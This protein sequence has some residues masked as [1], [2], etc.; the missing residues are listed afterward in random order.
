[1]KLQISFDIVDLD[2]AIEI[3]QKVAP[4]ADIL[5]VGALL[6]YKHGTKAVEEFRSAFPTK[7]L[8]VDAKIID[9]AKEAVT[10]LA[11]S[12]ADWITVMAGTSKQVI[13]SACTTAHELN[14]KVMIDLLDAHELGQS[15]LEAKSLGADA[16]LFHKPHDE[17]SSLLFFDKWD[18]V[19]GNT[20]LPIFVSGTLSRETIDK[21]IEL[22]PDGIIVGKAIID[23]TDPEAEARFYAEKSNT[24]ETSS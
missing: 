13:H 9:R 21:A 23:A 2:K 16:L 5:E 20:N 8:L 3:A 15:S 10:L 19:R 12:G 24:Q 18:M 1:M 11:H 14:K 6:L 17:E 22:K 4:S 7:T